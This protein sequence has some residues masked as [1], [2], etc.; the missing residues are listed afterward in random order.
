MLRGF[1]SGTLEP[2]PARRFPLGFSRGG[3][4]SNSFNVLSVAPPHINLLIEPHRRIRTPNGRAFSGEPSERSERPERR[5]GRRVRCNAMLGGGG[6]QEGDR[7]KH[8]SI[9][10]AVNTR[11]VSHS[12]KEEGQRLIRG[13]L[14]NPGLSK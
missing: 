7:R 6:G 14:L 10:C 11:S 9:S 5:R 8:A 2:F 12:A 13:R 1:C 4:M 3:R